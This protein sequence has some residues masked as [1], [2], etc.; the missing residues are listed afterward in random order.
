MIDWHVIEYLY[1]T[2][3]S[4][5]SDVMFPN[6]GL[7]SVS[8]LNYYDINHLYYFFEKQGIHLTVETCTK[9][10]WLYTISLDS[11]T[12][13]CPTQETKSLREEIETEGFYECF[14]ILDHKLAGEIIVKHGK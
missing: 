3:M 11:G 1:P 13:L 8:I 2:A 14:K 6:V 9:N 4:K 7:V 10:C 12:V 5:F